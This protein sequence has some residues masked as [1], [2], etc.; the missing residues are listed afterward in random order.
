MNASQQSR[1]SLYI[2]FQKIAFLQGEGA[3]EFGIGGIVINFEAH[4]KWK[5]VTE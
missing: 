5:A 4:K 3:G 2:L 1:N